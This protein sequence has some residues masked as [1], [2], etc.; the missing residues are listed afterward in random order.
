MRVL[1]NWKSSRLEKL[2]RGESS[3]ITRSQYLLYQM[4]V[5]E[6]WKGG[7]P[8]AHNHSF[9]LHTK[10]ERGRRNLNSCVCVGGGGERLGGGKPPG[11]DTQHCG[12]GQPWTHTDPS[13]GGCSSSGGRAEHTD[14]TTEHSRISQP[15][16][17]ITSLGSINQY[18]QVSHS[19]RNNSVGWEFPLDRGGHCGPGRMTH[20]GSRSRARPE[21]VSAQP[22]LVNTRHPGS[23]WPCSGGWHSLQVAL[24]IHP[25]L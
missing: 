14:K 5:L 22:G 7:I 8:E 13:T 4:L 15:Q 2:E 11:P 17:N 3:T 25:V 6:V 21:P 20:P 16:N 10:Q 18:E 9:R 1:S 24:G 23:A 19:G 12:C